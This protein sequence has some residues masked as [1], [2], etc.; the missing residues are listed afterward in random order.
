M[1]ETMNWTLETAINFAEEYAEALRKHA[2]SGSLLAEIRQA[3]ADYQR[4]EGCSCCRNIEAHKEAEKRLGALL[5][6]KPYED[7]S[8]FD[9]SLYRSKQWSITN[10]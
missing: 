4:A 9:W 5:D 8:G 2:V 7:G 10:V 6:A 1:V 3:F